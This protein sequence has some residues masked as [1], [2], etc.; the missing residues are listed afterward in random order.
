[1]SI[2]TV[3]ISLLLTPLQGLLRL[4]AWLRSLGATDLTVHVL[5]RMIRVFSMMIFDQ[6]PSAAGRP[7]NASRHG[8]RAGISQ[9][10]FKHAA[11]IRIADVVS[12]RVTPISK[13]P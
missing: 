2:S 4:R 1:M 7:V 3:F 8:P 10:A 9:Q 12:A 6:E 5:T 11:G 13:I